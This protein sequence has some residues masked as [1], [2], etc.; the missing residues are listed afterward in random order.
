MKKVNCNHNLPGRETILFLPFFIY[1]IGCPDPRQ[2][3]PGTVVK[4]DK[5]GWLGFNFF[6]FLLSG[7]DVWPK[8]NL[9][10]KFHRISE[11]G[12]DLKRRS[13]PTPLLKQLPYSRSHRWKYN[14]HNNN[15]M[16]LQTTE[17]MSHKRIPGWSKFYIKLPCFPFCFY[18]LPSIH[19]FRW[20]TNSEWFNPVH[21]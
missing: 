21:G 8:S 14:L 5:A 7:P 20:L 2:S 12:G 3:S 10:S 19:N 18:I 6:C 4:Q 13:N 17:V 16:I 11:F 15:V 9:S 1:T